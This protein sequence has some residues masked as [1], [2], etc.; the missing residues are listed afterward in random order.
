MPLTDD[1]SWLPIS[2]KVI[3]VGLYGVFGGTLAWGR[4]RTRVGWHHALLV[5][6]GALYG[7][8]DEWHQAFVPGR[9]AS[10]LDWIADVTGVLVGYSVVLT[11][12][13]FRAVRASRPA[14]SG[15]GNEGA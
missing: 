7:V 14:D 1:M 5:A 12:I 9:T 6:A 4:I 2:D 11:M 15:T 10:F 3:H 8:S 13:S